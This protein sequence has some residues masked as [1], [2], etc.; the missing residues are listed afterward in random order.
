MKFWSIPNGKSTCYFYNAYENMC[1][2]HSHKPMVCRS[3]PFAL[4]PSGV[5]I[6]YY[7]NCPNPPPMTFLETKEK[8]ELL[9]NTQ[10]SQANYRKEIKEWDENVQDSEKTFTNLLKYAIPSHPR[11]INPSSLT[12]DECDFGQNFKHFMDKQCQQ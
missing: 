7:G 1:R 9:I 3:Y 12:R 8:T 4:A 6:F 11:L 2:V 10:Q 5:S